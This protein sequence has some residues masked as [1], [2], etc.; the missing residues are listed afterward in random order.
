MKW[1]RSRHLWAWVPWTDSNSVFST[2]L[3]PRRCWVPRS[4]QPS[5]YRADFVQFWFRTI[6]GETFTMSSS[7]SVFPSMHFAIWTHASQWSRSDLSSTQP[8]SSRYHYSISCK[9]CTVVRNTLC[10]LGWWFDLGDNVYSQKPRLPDFGWNFWKIWN[11]LGRSLWVNRIQNTKQ[12]K[13]V[14]LYFVFCY[15]TSAVV[16]QNTKQ[17]DI[18][19]VPS[20]FVA[21]RRG[22][23][24]IEGIDVAE[25]RTSNTTLNIYL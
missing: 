18:Y 2:S 24:Q 16:R 15:S 4:A 1:L 25:Y 3:Q 6:T 19:F 11:D 20:S 9:Q 5:Q 7:Y 12:G 21:V 10:V 8:S 13:F 22:R 17:E 14:F 23:L